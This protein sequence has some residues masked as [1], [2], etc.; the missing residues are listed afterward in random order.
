MSAA[1]V[2]SLWLHV[3]CFRHLLAGCCSDASHFPCYQFLYVADICIV[4]LAIGRAVTCVGAVIAAGIA[5]IILL[6]GV[7]RCYYD[8]SYPHA[9]DYD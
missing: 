2:E 3:M 9:Y 5:M 1:A 8:Y 4:H 7:Y 6:L